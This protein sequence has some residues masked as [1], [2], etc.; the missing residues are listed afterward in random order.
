M[1]LC[2]DLMILWSG[3]EGSIVQQAKLYLITIQASAGD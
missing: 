3:L 2:N 1:S